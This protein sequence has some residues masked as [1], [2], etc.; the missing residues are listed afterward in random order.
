MFCYIIL[1]NFSIWLRNDWQ[2]DDKL[3]PLSVPIVV[4][5]DSQLLMNLVVLVRSGW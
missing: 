1:L 5:P 3:K 4:A 2:S